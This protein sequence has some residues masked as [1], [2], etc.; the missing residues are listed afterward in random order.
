M[1]PKSKFAEPRGSIEF[2]VGKKDTSSAVKRGD[3]GDDTLAVGAPEV[4]ESDLMAKKAAHAG[5]TADQVS[6]NPLLQGMD[7][8]RMFRRS[9]E[10]WDKV[11]QHHKA[12]IRLGRKQGSYHTKPSTLVEG[13]LEGAEGAGA[14]AGAAGTEEPSE[15]YDADALAD[16]FAVAGGVTPSP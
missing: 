10:T 1:P 13:S 7:S 3:S 12:S 8:P 15:D 14:G 9:S 2:F 4:N 6:V 11:Q 16:L 5:V